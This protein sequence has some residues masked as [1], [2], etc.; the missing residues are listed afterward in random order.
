M[1]GVAETVAESDSRP[2]QIGARLPLGRR[3]P[4]GMKNLPRFARCQN[5][6]A[7]DQPRN[8]RVHECR[9]THRGGGQ[10]QLP[11]PRPHRLLGG[12]G[13]LIPAIAI[14][15]PVSEFEDA[16]R[17]GFATEGDDRPCGIRGV[18]QGNAALAWTSHW[19]N[20]ARGSLEYRQRFPV[21]RTIDR[22]GAHDAP[23]AVPQLG[24]RGLARPLGLGIGRQGGFA[25]HHRGNEDQSLGNGAIVQRRDQ[26]FRA[27][28]IACVECSA[29]ARLD[30]ACRMDH[31]VGT[32][33]QPAK[34]LAVREVALDRLEIVP[35]KLRMGAGT[36]GQDADPPARGDQGRD[37]IAAQKPGRP[38]DRRKLG[39]RWMALGRAGQS[40]A[41][42]GCGAKPGVVRSL[43]GADRS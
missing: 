41:G 26:L 33:D 21:P 14:G 35:G 25:R 27:A 39:R 31:R 38:G 23:S 43:L 9:P 18:N 37:D 22:A 32:V 13:N 19:K 40:A 15:A 6:R 1:R 8:R 4:V 7:A 11:H 34:R 36:A 2:P 29:V 17:V 5:R 28:D 20:A 30:Q 12:G 16:S 24:K 10:E 3:T 42:T